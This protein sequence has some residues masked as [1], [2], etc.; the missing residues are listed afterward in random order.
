[1]QR[2]PHSTRHAKP[3]GEGTEPE[4]VHSP[5]PPPFPLNPTGLFKTPR[6]PGGIKRS[7]QKRQGGALKGPTPP[8]ASGRQGALRLH[9]A[10]RGAGGRGGAG[11]RGHPALPSLALPAG[12]GAPEPGS[13]SRESA[14]K[15]QVAS[16]R[17]GPNKANKPGGNPLFLRSCLCFH[18]H[19]RLRLCVAGARLG[20]SFC[21]FTG[22]RASWQSSPSPLGWSRR[23]YTASALGKEAWWVPSVFEAATHGRPLAP[24]RPWSSA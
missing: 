22:F 7:S 3:S 24:T 12:R 4:P 1:M 14:N 17:P 6:T 20:G 8:R 19:L 23:G 21:I 5:P 18:A 2:K 16:R 9:G 15:A 13:R 11:P 10:E